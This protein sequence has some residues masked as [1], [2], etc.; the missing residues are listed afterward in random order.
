MKIVLFILIPL[1]LL[2]QGADAQKV[3][4]G[5]KGGTDIVN[6]RFNP[7]K[8]YY[9]IPN[10]LSYDFGL[11]LSYNLTKKVQIQFES[12]FIEKGHK[13]YSI[14]P[15]SRWIFKYGYLS[16]QLVFIFKPIQ[17]LNVEIGS[18]LCHTLYAKLKQVPGQVIEYELSLYKKYEI[19]GL[20]GSGF[21]FLDNAYINIRYVYSFTPLNESWV[22]ERGVKS[23]KIYNQ[24]LSIGL[25]YYFLKKT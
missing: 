17:K 2:Y 16:N 14:S 9:G 18:E 7:T 8:E 12:G 10:R 4:F 25:R 22:S 11:L 15:D 23:Q 13:E 3:N 20:I 5:I 6:N 24:Y 19:S 21:R 1:M